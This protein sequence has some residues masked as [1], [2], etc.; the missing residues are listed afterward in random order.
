MVSVKAHTPMWRWEHD[1]AGQVAGVGLALLLLARRRFPGTVFVLLP[2]AGLAADHI[3][4]F[5][6]GVVSIGA[7]VAVYSGGR[8]LP[9]RRSLA[10]LGCGTAVNVATT[11]ASPF[12]EMRTGWWD[13]VFYLSWIAGAWWLG[14]LGRLRAA[15]LT[16]LQAR[17]TRLEHAR[18]AH[19]RAVLA[20][21]RSRIAREL[22][23]VVAH[24][25]SV[26]T[27]QATA[28][29]RVIARSPDRARQALE[30]IEETGRQALSEM[31]RIVGVLRTSASADA[32]RGPQP[33]LA[34]IPD[35]LAQVRETGLAVALRTEGVARALPPGLELTLYRVVQESL[36]NVLKHA[37]PDAAAEVALRFEPGAVSVRVE[38]DGAGPPGGARGG[39]EPGHGLLGMRERVSLFGGDLEA[40]PRPGGGFSVRAR[41][42]EN[43]SGAERP[44]TAAA[45]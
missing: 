35:L 34:D 14:R 20:E 15:H 36:T 5:V 16:E 1:L 40:G 8:H 11:V 45:R 3:G 26:M 7:A 37:G 43:R 21:E 30:D 38:D 41:V 10:G 31:R 4:V 19:A 29:R 23:D 25:V 32:D 12:N 33:G 6:Q 24:H 44:E 18:D 39:D 22:H 28:G 27:V 13:V 9:L 42:P 2:L 17:A